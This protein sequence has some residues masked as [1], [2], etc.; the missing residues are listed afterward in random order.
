[1]DKKYGLNLHIDKDWNIVIDV[2]AGNRIR[3]KVI[4]PDSFCQIVAKNV[5]LKSVTSGILPAGSVAYSEKDG[6]RFVAL[7]LGQDRIDVTY[8][9]T[10]YENFPVPRLIYG[11]T[12]DIQG[13]ITKVDV[14]VADRGILRDDTKL[15]KYPF[16]NVL[17]FSMCTGGNTF[18]KIKELRQ[19]A[20]IPNYIF[21]MPDNNDRYSVENTKLNMEYRN[22]LEFMQN[23][24]PNFYYTDVLIPSGKTLKD[25]ISI[26]GG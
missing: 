12:V 9:K 26:N 24:D 19:L 21:S 6:T 13:K 11:F 10:T 4:A 5:K 7:E 18:P 1:M 2:R 17:G 14:A 22:L 8:E 23:K 16:S 20:G 15:Y 25:F 3:H